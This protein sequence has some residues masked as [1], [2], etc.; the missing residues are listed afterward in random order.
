MLQHIKQDEL[1]EIL[2][3]HELW[4]KNKPHGE[5]AD[6]SYANL[7]DA[8]L[9]GRDLRG[10]SFSHANLEGADLHDTKLNDASFLYANLKDACF[11]Y[12]DLSRANFYYAKL[13]SA[14][15]RNAC[16]FKTGLEGADLKGANLDYSSLPL[17]C[18]SLHA[19][20][21]D[22]QIIQIIYHAV[23]AGLSSNNTSKIVKGELRKLIDLAN[24]FHRV[25]ECGKIEDK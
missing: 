22:R 7:K 20:F 8:D 5:L 14:D 4:L 10:I 16:L 13:Q 17:W 12:A 24:R 6:L 19:Q 9:H 1:N 23:K 25:D 21:D 15:L 11:V 3:K 2:R 18:G